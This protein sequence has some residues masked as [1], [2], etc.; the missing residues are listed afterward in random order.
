MYDAQ[1]IEAIREALDKL[2]H[3]YGKRILGIVPRM[4]G[5]CLVTEAGDEY[6][7]RV[8]EPPNDWC[9]T[10]ELLERRGRML[11]KRESA[12]LQEPS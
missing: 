5:W 2:S 1:A 8:E 9:G 12:S 3:L 6:V 10:S 7:T 4:R 11:G